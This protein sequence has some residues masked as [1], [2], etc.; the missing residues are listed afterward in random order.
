LVRVSLQREATGGR[1]TGDFTACTVV[2][3]WIRRAW[4]DTL[5]AMVLFSM[6]PIFMPMNPKGLAG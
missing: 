3:R 2:A 4:L 1:S 6:A 5:A